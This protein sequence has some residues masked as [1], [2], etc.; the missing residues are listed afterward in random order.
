MKTLS[1]L[2]PACLWLLVSQI[3]TATPY[4]VA[5]DL[6][7]YTNSASVSGDATIL[8]AAHAN[9][10]DIL[11]IG[12]SDGLV[13]FL[14]AV[15]LV[16]IYNSTSSFRQHT[17]AVR[18]LQVA[19]FNGVEYAI[20]AGIDYKLI[21]WQVSTASVLASRNLDS[22]MLYDVC[23]NG[24]NIYVVSNA[25]YLYKLSLPTGATVSS[26]NVGQASYSVSCNAG[27]V[28]VG[29]ANGKISIYNA[30]TLALRT[31]FMTP[32]TYPTAIFNVPS[33]KVVY[34]SSDVDQRFQ[35]T[36]EN[37]T[38]VNTFWGASPRT[39]GVSPSLDP[40][41][42]WFAGDGKAVRFDTTTNL[43]TNTIDFAMTASYSGPSVFAVTER[44]RPNLTIY[45]A[46]SSSIYV[47]N[48]TVPDNAMGIIP[49]TLR[50]TGTTLSTH[51]SSPDLACYN[52]DAQSLVNG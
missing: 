52:G 35:I 20:T 42:I 32:T 29:S 51:P 33:A 44:L 5:V 19:N 48:A 7:G 43:F 28:A 3:V 1:F 22:S 8:T 31:S 40:T 21:I 10:S 11:V 16:P 38:T 13:A 39:T 27:E 45:G 2:L 46:M 18:K 17:K 24:A 25:G 50:N 34:T 14:N 47:F 26:V 6:S 23:W 41:K 12:R 4:T 9:V 37:G 30:I 15:T 49:Y 36:S